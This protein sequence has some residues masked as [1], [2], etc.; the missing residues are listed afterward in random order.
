M[1]RTARAAGYEVVI[2]ARLEPGLPV[3]ERTPEFTIIRAPFDMWLAFPI[4]GKRRVARYRRMLERARAQDSAQGGARVGDA[5]PVSAPPLAPR[6]MSAM[7]RFRRKAADLADA[8]HFPIRRMLATV[9]LFPLRPMGWAAALDVAAEPADIWH[10]MWAGSLPAQVSLRRKFGGRSIYDSRDVYIHSRT[11]GT[12]PGP[13]QAPFR[14][15]ER[16]WARQADAVIT[17]NQAYAEII[18]A[19]LGVP[20]AAVVMNCPNRYAVPEPRPDR[21]RELLGIPAETRIVLYQGG[22]MTERGIEEGMEAILQV[23]DAVLVLLGYGALRDQFAAMAAAPPYAGRVYLVDAVPP[24]EL[25]PWT[26]SADV[27]LMAIQPTTLNHQHTTPQKLWEALA[28]G[29]PIVASDLPGMA[30]IVRESGAGLLCNPVDPASIAAAIRTLIELPEPE[31]A[32]Y[33]RAALAAA[34]DRYN[35]E[36]QA[37]ELLAVYAGLVRA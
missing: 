23:P 30:A 9:S 8:A 36:F 19:S 33:R 14:W 32:A 22:L 35:W 24:E 10:G 28:A 1:V 34:A 11:V 5:A 15:F 31:L 20:I 25:M 17:V 13:L 21:F 7:A 16:R 18:S 4:I 29:V 2:Y 6:S 37:Q 27:M 3:I 12:L 26:A